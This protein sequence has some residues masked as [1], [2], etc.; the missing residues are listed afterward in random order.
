MCQ[1]NHIYHQVKNTEKIFHP[2]KHCNLGLVVLTFL[3]ALA[4]LFCKDTTKQMAG[5]PGP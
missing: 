4:R 2:K 3:G 1:Q 5:G